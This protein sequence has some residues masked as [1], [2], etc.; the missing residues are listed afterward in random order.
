MPQEKEAALR[1]GYSWRYVY[2]SDPSLMG[3]QIQQHGLTY[4]SP[5]NML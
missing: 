2:A 1:H 5:F 3:P 4:S